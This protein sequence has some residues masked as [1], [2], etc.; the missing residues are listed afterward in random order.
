MVIGQRS[1][2]L[3]WLIGLGMAVALQVP[4]TASFAMEARLTDDAFVSEKSP[5]GPVG[6]KPMLLVSSQPTTNAYL[7]FDLSNLPAGVTGDDIARA[8]LR[9]GGR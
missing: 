6:A 7:R 8:T 9:S 3:K 2:H 5:R 1:G 4:I